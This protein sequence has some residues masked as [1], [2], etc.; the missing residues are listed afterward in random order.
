VREALRALRSRLPLQDTE[1]KLAAIRQGAR[2]SFPSGSIDQMLRE[3]ESGYLDG[4]AR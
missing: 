2:H 1:R 4:T 3:I